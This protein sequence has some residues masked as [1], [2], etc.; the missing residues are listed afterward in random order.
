MLGARGRIADPWQDYFKVK[1][2]ITEKM[3]RSVGMK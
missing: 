1:Q 2:S 3:K